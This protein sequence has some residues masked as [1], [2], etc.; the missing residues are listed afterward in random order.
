MPSTSLDSDD[1]SSSAGSGY[2]PGKTGDSEVDSLWDSGQEWILIFDNLLKHPRGKTKGCK[3]DMCLRE[4]AESDGAAA[5]PVNTSS[6]SD[7][8]AEEFS[9]NR[10]RSSTRSLNSSQSEQFDYHYNDFGKI[11]SWWRTKHL[12]LQ[13]FTDSSR[14]VHL[15]PPRGKVAGLFWDV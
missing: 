15:P 1:S 11:P 5:K 10:R 14:L 8:I 13:P 3:C 7:F 2:I 9:F 12:W 4:K 6:Y